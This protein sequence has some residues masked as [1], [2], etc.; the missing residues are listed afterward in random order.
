MGRRSKTNPLKEFVGFVWTLPW[1]LGVVI[2]TFAFIVL[3]AMSGPVRVTSV[4]PGQVGSVINQSLIA[5]FAGIGQYVV[6]AV[7]LV[8]AA[9]S[10]S[11]RKRRASL[12]NNVAQAKSAR[13]LN[14]MS[15][16]EFE[17]LVD[18]AY[19]Q[20]G[21]S[22]TETGGVGADGGVDLSL[23]KNGEMFLVQCKQ[24]KAFRVGVKVVRELYGVMALRGATGGFVVTSGRFTES[25]KAFAADCNVQLIDGPELMG[26]IE[27]A[28]RGMES[29]GGRVNSELEAHLAPIS[30]APFCPKC[31]ASMVRRTVRKGVYTGGEFFGCSQFPGCRGIRQTRQL[32]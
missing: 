26:M 7:A 31:G 14:A 19:R 3:H 17:M 2:A 1:W 22:V 4:Q 23:T 8:G 24:W 18:E 10:F 25:A 12:L 29:L 16:A 9:I 27:S 32:Y 5:L 6:P 30:T 21:Y 13:A 15:W 11:R 28:T 20:Q